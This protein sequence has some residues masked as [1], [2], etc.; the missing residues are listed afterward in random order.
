MVQ[1]TLRT[2]HIK[3]LLFQTNL[4]DYYIPCQV[5]W[6]ALLHGLIIGAFLYYL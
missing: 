1:M 6:F 5:A 3:G 2:A 4:R